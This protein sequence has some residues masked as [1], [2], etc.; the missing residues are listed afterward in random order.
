MCAKGVEWNVGKVFFGDKQVY[1]FN[2]LPEPAH[3]RPAFINL[4]QYYAEAYLALRAAELPNLEVRW[5]NTSSR[6]SRAPTACHARHRHAGGPLP[7]SSPTMWSP[8]TGRARRCA[9]CSARR[10]RAGSSATAS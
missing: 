9:R 6:W 10:A 7:A 4:Q 5:K 1:S 3:E 2:L 8:A